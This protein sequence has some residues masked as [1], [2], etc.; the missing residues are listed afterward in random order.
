MRTLGAGGTAVLSTSQKRETDALVLKLEALGGSQRSLAEGIGSFELPWLGCWEMLYTAGATP[1][2]SELVDAGGERLAL[3]GARQF[4]FGPTDARAELRGVS[5][6]GGVS[7]ECT[8]AA[9]GGAST[10]LLTASDGS[11]S[12]LADFAYRIEYA[13]ARTFSFSPSLASPL[14]A[15]SL[16]PLDPGSL[17]ATL[18]PPASAYQR[19]ISYLSPRLWISRS[20]DGSSLA[21]MRRCDARALAPPRARLD[22]TAPCS[23]TG[24]GRPMCR[25]QALF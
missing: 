12:K 19:V 8:Y 10:R 22:L 5:A 17:R 21:V 1:F 2:R 15:A 23:E 20:S 3:I 6:D 25:K 4:V 11:L 14:E 7:L 13:P 24:W 9:S 16:T 18:P